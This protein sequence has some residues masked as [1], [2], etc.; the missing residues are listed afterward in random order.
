MVTMLRF[1]YKI[2]SILSVFIAQNQRFEGPD[3]DSDTLE[4]VLASLLMTETRA[5]VDSR[6]NWTCGGALV[7][8]GRSL[9]S[10]LRAGR[11]AAQLYTV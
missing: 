2:C 3:R 4:Q 10:G 8:E 7:L 11:R 9:D 1:V 5:S 6:T